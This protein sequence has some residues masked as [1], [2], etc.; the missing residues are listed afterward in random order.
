M[1]LNIILNLAEGSLSLWERLQTAPIWLTAPFVILSIGLV[2]FTLWLI[3]K[4]LGPKKKEVLEQAP[5]V[6]AELIAEKYR[7][8]E[9]KG[10]PVDEA[11]KE[12]EQWRAEKQSGEIIIS[13]LGNISVGKSS[14][15]KAMLPDVIPVESIVTDV[16]GGSTRETKRFIGIVQLAIS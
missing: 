13:L 3:W 10:I 16:I 5:L 9:A 7:E 11:Y 14:L 4:L 1:T 8:A 15:V 2:T 6:N 12:L